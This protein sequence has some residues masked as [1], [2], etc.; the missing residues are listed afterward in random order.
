VAIFIRTDVPPA[1]PGT[2][3]ATTGTTLSGTYTTTL[4]MY[5]ENVTLLAGE[6]K[7]LIS[8]SITLAKRSLVVAVF[9]LFSDGSTAVYLRLYIGGV[10]VASASMDIYKKLRTLHGYRVLPPGSYT[11]TAAGYN[12]A[13][14][15]TYI[16]HYASTTGLPTGSLVVYVVPLE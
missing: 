6:E 14:Y 1:A 15:S 5:Y 10:L 2:A 13:T 11:V 3:A 4:D 7:T 16:C 12:S 8:V 9:N